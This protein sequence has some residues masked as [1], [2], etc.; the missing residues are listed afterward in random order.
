MNP[1]EL[2]AGIEIKREEVDFQKLNMKNERK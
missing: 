1:Y 2:P